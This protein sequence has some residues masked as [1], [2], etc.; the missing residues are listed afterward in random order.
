MGENIASMQRPGGRLY[1]K[2]SSYRYRDPHVKDKTVA[3]VLSY[4]MGISISQKDSLY[5]E[6]GP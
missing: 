3:T 1:I 6:M 2:M 4:N 5:I